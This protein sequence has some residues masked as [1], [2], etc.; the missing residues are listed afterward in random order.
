LKRTVLAEVQ[1][2]N[3][4]WKEVKRMAKNSLLVK[5]CDGPMF[6]LRTTRNDGDDE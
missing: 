5:I 4:S 1:E 2:Q 3:V 6:H